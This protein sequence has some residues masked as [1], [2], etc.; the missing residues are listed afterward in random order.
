[1]LEDVTDTVTS[2]GKS[3]SIF[4]NFN[5]KLFIYIIVAIIIEIVAIVYGMGPPAMYL[6]LV[7]FIPLSLYIFVTYGFAWF[8]PDGPYSNKKISWPP[9]I[10][11]CPDFLTAYKAGSLP[12]CIDTVGVSSNGGFKSNLNGKVTF[13]GS[14][15]TSI[16]GGTSGNAISFFGVGW[17]PTQVGG[18]KIP[19]LCS[20]L[21]TAGLTW[22][23]IYDG[24]QCYQNGSVIAAAV[25]GE[26][27]CN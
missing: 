23:G 18:E 14:A 21:R 27:T 17:F 26:G 2:G 10:N 6:A 24:Q 5:L 19:Q 15:P 22:E 8:G 1:M 12:G 3:F 16:S 13:S 11:S 20:R 4:G 9:A 25:T 7:I